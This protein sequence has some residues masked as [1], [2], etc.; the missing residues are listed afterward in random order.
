[1]PILSPNYPLSHGVTRVYLVYVRI[2]K[3]RCGSILSW[4]NVKLEHRTM[5]PQIKLNGQHRRRFVVNFETPPQYLTCS[6]LP[7]THTA[8]GKL[9][10]LLHGTP[11]PTTPRPF[12]SSAGFPKPATSS[13]RSTSLTPTSPASA[14]ALR[15][16]KRPRPSAQNSVVSSAASPP[17]P[18][19]FRPISNLA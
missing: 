6:N 4:S 18:T 3:C 9:M 13:P 19:N 14:K 12:S 5:L 2:A 17:S 7:Y 15:N 8:T 11:S 10:P 16:G 1:M